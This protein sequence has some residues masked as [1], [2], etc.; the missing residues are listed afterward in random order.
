MHGG[1]AGSGAPLKNQN[2]LKSGHYTR[3]AI[4]S[5]NELQALLRDARELIRKI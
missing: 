2:A 5:R 4:E 3:E 1:A